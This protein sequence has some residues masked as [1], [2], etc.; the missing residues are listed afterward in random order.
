M[1]W[2]GELRKREGEEAEGTIC[3][4]KKRGRGRVRYI[5]WK[6]GLGRVESAVI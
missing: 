6:V 4:G 2:G 3:G 1:C 5:Q